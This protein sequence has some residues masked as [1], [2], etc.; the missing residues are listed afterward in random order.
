MNGR[1]AVHMLV[2]IVAKGGN[3]LFNVAP[4]PDGKWHDEA[5]KLFEE[6]GNWMEV[7]NEAIYGTRAIA[8]YKERKVCL[9][10]KDDAIYA[11]YLAE[12]NETGMP[13]KIFLSSISP[14]KKANVSLLGVDSLLKWEKV[15]NG[16]VVDIPEQF[17]KIPPCKYA[18]VIKIDKTK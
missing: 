1:K 2:D 15:G 12:E 8:P 5:Y 7:N 17:Q 4:G 18:W 14:D 3:L 10:Q 11:I 16:F 9:T 13:S 6:I